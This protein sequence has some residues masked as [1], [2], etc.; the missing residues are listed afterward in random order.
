MSAAVTL[1]NSDND[2]SGEFHMEPSSDYFACASSDE[3]ASELQ[4]KVDSYYNYVISSNLVELWR[5]AYRAYYGM[6]NDNQDG[7]GWGVFDV[8]GLMAGGDQGEIVRVKVNHFANLIT[9]QLTLVTSQR[10]TLDC[11]ATN[12]DAKSIVAAMLGDG[13][14]EYFM[15]E[16]KL[17]RNYYTAVE[18][19]LVMSE[20]YV[21]L[22]W[23]AKGGKPI[24]KGP[25]G[26]TLYEG[27]LTA[28]NFTAFQVVK[29]VNKNSS[30]AQCWY[31]THDKMNR[32]DCAAKYA[33]G[34]ED[35]RRKILSSGADDRQAMTRTY[36]DPSKMIAA[37]GFG[38]MDSDDIPYMEFY[39]K[40]TPS[41]PYGR[42]TIFV[43]GDTKLFD[44]PLPFREMPVY[45]CA[46][47]NIIGT[48]FG[49]AS[50][51]DI[52]AIQ[53]LIDKLY[54]CVTSN[55]LGNGLNNF[56]LPP[57]MGVEVTKLA[58]GR[59]LIESV[60]K[61][62]VLT[63]LSTPAEVYNFIDK[64]ESVAEKLTGISPVNRG[65]IPTADMSGTAMAFM[66][67]QAITS[68]SG[69]QTAANQLLEELGTGTI[70]ILKDYAKTPRLAVIVGKQDRPLLK[71]YMGE[72]LEPI[73]NVV[74]DSTGAVGKSMTGR[75]AIADNL[76]RT[77]G[78]IK[79]PQEYLTVLKTGELEPMTRAPLMENV[80]IQQ[81]NEWLLEG[82]A[83]QVIR[84]DGHQQHIAEHLSLLSSPDAREDGDLVT[85]V[86]DH[87]TAHEQ[88]EAM[89]EQQHPAI[90]ASQG[91]G[92]LPQPAPPPAI[93]APSG[94]IQAAATP[95][96]IVSQKAAQIKAPR[97]P[98]L[99]PGSDIQSQEAYAQLK[100]AQGQ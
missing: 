83:P 4:A 63:L 9:H 8:G 58:G 20:G 40:I 43:D 36:S 61:P 10:P 76:L 80:L 87:V 33:V 64:L 85:R 12:S 47:K 39:H 96:S 55:T 30:D 59:N 42:Y 92:P 26:T 78:M 1:N 67:A 79:T 6:R 97:M 15:R 41:L 62:E 82:K 70:N 91:F 90:L 46:A 95:D 86:L 51:F 93:Q 49:W 100:Q 66:A 89:M 35:L 29:D 3:I 2:N 74:C 52:L 34:D 50:S 28:K 54:T 7:Y 60:V 84:T 37:T 56:W 75:I 13:I 72:D 16:K 38:M 45:R 69:I 53:E 81:E 44:G 17:E 98:G 57:D 99:P 5:R 18:T 65:D 27:D 88:A 32:Y 77:P 21:V 11:R 31:I 23:D 19:A 22:G 73:N 24:G 68:N 94:A 48:S 71:E 14:V 25:N